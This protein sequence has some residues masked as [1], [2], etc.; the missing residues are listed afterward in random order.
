MGSEASGGSG[1]VGKGESDIRARG[2]RAGT[3]RRA[4]AGEADTEAP[5]GTL[6]R[7]ASQ[8]RRQWG[9]GG[10]GPQRRG[11]RGQPG[12]SCGGDQDWGE[13]G[14][15]RASGRSPEGPRS[16]CSR[17]PSPTL[18]PPHQAPCAPHTGQGTLS[19]AQEA[20]TLP[21]PYCP[22]VPLTPEAVYGFLGRRQQSTT[23][24]VASPRGRN[25]CPPPN[26]APSWRPRSQVQVPERR[27]LPEALTQA[28]SWPPCRS[29]CTRSV[30]VS[31]S[32]RLSP[33]EDPV[34]RVRGPPHVPG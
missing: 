10:P 24:R 22:S 9:I 3:K 31:A 4:E 1:V 18:G 5:P 19:S 20:L 33:Y 34:T 29:G 15:G 23:A 12:G 25:R 30:P 2:C 6:L 21:H 16:P 26:P 14:A 27:L 17:K 7:E 8:R 11:S 13:D 28:G 32:K